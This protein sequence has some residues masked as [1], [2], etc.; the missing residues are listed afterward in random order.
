MGT[1][2]KGQADYY[3]PGDFNAVCSMCGH[4]RKAS[5]MVKNWQGLY[6]CR[7][8]DEPRQPQDFVRGIPDNP[9]TPWAQ[10]PSQTFV[11]FCSINTRCALPGFGI[12]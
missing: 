12:P 2:T 4:K 3:S 8:H 9:G 6:R 5:T 1:P 10:P 7:E 11:Y